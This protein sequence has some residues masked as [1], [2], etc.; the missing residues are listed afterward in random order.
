MKALTVVCH[1]TIGPDGGLDT[2]GQADITD[3][4]YRIKQ[5]VK[6]LKSIIISSPVRGSLETAQII[7]RFLKV[8]PSE[9][10]L[11]LHSPKRS[12][13]DIFFELV[14][15]MDEESV[16]MVTQ[17]DYANSLIYNYARK[18]MSR[19]YLPPLPVRK[20]EAN[21]LYCNTGEVLHLFHRKFHCMP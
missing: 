9:S 17:H 10:E 3:L 19:K 16:I 2:N 7:G 1:G 8:T 21:I 12:E 18:V 5:E 13:E 15:L 14:E 6:G 4:S 20:G 11:L